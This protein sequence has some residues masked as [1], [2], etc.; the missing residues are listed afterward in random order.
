MKLKKFRI[1]GYR[2]IQ[3]SGWVD[4]E[5][6]AVIVGKNESGKTSL[7]KALWKLNPFHEV[8]Y[9]IDRE[10]PTG[11]RKEKSLDKTVVTAF[12]VLSADEQAKLAEVHESAKGVTEI[13]VKR[14][15]KGTCCYSF[16]PVSPSNSERDIP[17]VVSQLNE[18]LTEPPAEFTDHFKNQY[19]PFFKKLR[20]EVANG[21]GSKRAIEMCVELRIN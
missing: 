3:D 6:I 19:R 7:L 16:L 17:W 9:N 20:D 14:N 13:Q 4:V 5:D 8:S 10:F 1:Q 15:Y 12:F 21:G 11:R 2:C 18:C